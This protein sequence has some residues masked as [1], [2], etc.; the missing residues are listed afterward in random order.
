MLKT[1]QISGRLTQQSCLLEEGAVMRTCVRS[2]VAFFFLWL[3]VALIPFE[4]QLRIFG[5]ASTAL[6]LVGFL[7]AVFWICDLMIGKG[8]IREFRGKGLVILVLAGYA[9]STMVNGLTQSDIRAVITVLELAVMVLLLVSLVSSMERLDQICKAIFVSCTISSFLAFLAPKLIPDYQV[10][11]SQNTIRFY[12][13]SASVARLSLYSM[14]GV[15][16]SYV[17]VRMA[18]DMR[19]R[20]F[21][22]ACLM[23]NGYCL[24][25]T[26]SL[27]AFFSIMMGF[28]SLIF[29][30]V[31][32]S[33]S[34]SAKIR[35]VF[36]IFVLSAIAM[37]FFSL[38]GFQSSNVYKRVQNRIDQ[39]RYDDWYNWCSHRL[40]IWVA[41]SEVVKE[42]PAFG[43]GRDHAPA[44]I[45]GA[46]P[47]PHKEQWRGAHN[48]VLSMA[49]EFGLLPTIPF[50]ALIGWVTFRL[51][52]TITSLST[53]SDLR[54][55]Y[56]GEGLFISLTGLL[57]FG[58]GNSCQR[59]KYLW[60]IMA[61]SIIYTSIVRS[62]PSK[63]LKA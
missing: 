47:G 54:S 59:H 34:F 19:A 15:F 45:G 16:F 21:F 10:Y 3:F 25:R 17:Y 36:F 48:M 30:S 22:L 1:K 43:V 50:L 39:I 42:Y 46:F 40:G 20:V 60:I 31:I 4:A 56:L 58:M 13:I 26:I 53:R 29:I 63:S 32:N 49:S 7:A 28:L 57:A 12:G 38:S 2:G 41:A 37:G 33:R 11:M 6:P 35:T 18:Q 51:L 5:P 8:R 14:F 61:L 44:A 24:I 52:R 9:V 23:A 62:R 55:R 27:T